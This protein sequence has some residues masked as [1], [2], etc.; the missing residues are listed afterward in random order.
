MTKSVLNVEGMSCQHCVKAVTEA[1]S[2]I[3]G[4]SDVAVSLEKKTVTFTHDPEKAPLKK[5]ADEIEDIGY[6]VSK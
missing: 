2:A 1:V 3:P 6:D 4:V 5:I